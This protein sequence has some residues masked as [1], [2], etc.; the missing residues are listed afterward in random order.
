MFE[1][2]KKQLRKE[3]F[4]INTSIVMLL[5][6]IITEAILMA[7]GIFTFNLISLSVIGVFIILTRKLF[8]TRFIKLFSYTFYSILDEDINPEDK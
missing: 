5:L 1:E 3:I 2:T 4:A 7:C 8:K 6:S